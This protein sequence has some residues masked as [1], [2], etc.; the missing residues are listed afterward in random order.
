M[1]VLLA[2]WR[3]HCQWGRSQQTL[4]HQLSN[5]C[6][7][8]YNSSEQLLESGN[9]V[10]VEQPSTKKRMVFNGRGGARSNRA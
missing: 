5:S 7:G 1:L 6:K 4:S 9:Q 8:D 2:S 3:V 10:C